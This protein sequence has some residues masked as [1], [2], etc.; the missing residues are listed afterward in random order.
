V[1]F[2]TV[3]TQLPFDRLVKA[4][5]DLAPRLG[6]RVFAQ[7]SEGRYTPRNIEWKPFIRP[8]EVDQFFREAEVIVAHAG[9]GT[10]LTAR[11][12]GKP[13]ILMPRVAALGEHRNDHQLATVGALEGRPGIYVARDEAALEALLSQPLTAPEDA[14]APNAN[15][16]RLRAHLSGLIERSLAG[17]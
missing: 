2:V 7:T 16:D 11:K 13:V 9:I 12:L 1:I 3:G 15:R 5:D 14:E 4:V 17:A 6:K 10:I 8:L